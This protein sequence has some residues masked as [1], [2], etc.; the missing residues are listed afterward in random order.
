MSNADDFP[1][2]GDLELRIDVRAHVQCGAYIERMWGRLTHVDM[3]CLSSEEKAE[4]REDTEEMHTASQVPA[5]CKRIEKR[6][7]DGITEK[8][9]MVLYPQ[10]DRAAFSTPRIQ[11]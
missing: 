3:R 5:P 11:A 8:V 6:S 4:N 2:Y 1:K 9:D 10:K 7:E